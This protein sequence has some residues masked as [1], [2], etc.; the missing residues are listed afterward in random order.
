MKKPEPKEPELHD[1]PILIFL[2]PL[3]LVIV[4]AALTK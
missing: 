2:I 3:V 1:P 4:Y